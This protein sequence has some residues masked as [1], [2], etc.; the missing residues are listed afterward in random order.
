MSS[1]DS[2]AHEARLGVLVDRFQVLQESD[3]SIG[4]GVMRDEAGEHFGELVELVGC[5]GVLKA[6]FGEEPDAEQLP[7]AIGGYAIQ[8]VL[9]RGVSGVVYRAVDPNGRVVA[10][11]VMHE[12]LALSVEALRRFEREVEVAERL[13]HPAIVSMFR[14][15]EADGRLF[16][17]M[18]LIDGDTLAA[19]TTRIHDEGGDPNKVLDEYGVAD[20]VGATPKERFARR[21]ALLCAPV[22][23]ALHHAAGR[24]MIHRDLK[25]GNLL[26]GR[27]GRLKVADFGLAK[28]LGEELTSTVAVLGTPGF[29]SPEQA[30]GR[31]REVTGASDIYGLAG[32]IYRV[33]SGEYP[34]EAPSFNE[35]LAA[36]MHER[37]KSI[38]EY[39]AD[40]PR[41][42]ARVLARC[43]EKAPEDRYPT[44]QLLATD[45]QRIALGK[46]PLSSRIPAARRA[47]RFAERHRAVLGAGAAVVLLGVVAFLVWS[48]RPAGLEFTVLPNAAAFLNDQRI[49]PGSHEL[50]RGAY[51]LV[52]RL[53]GWVETRKTFDL[54][55]GDNT[56]FDIVLRPNDPNDLAKI[57][58]VLGGLP[59]ADFPRGRGIG[60][61]QPPVSDGKALEADLKKLPEQWR[62]QPVGYLRALNLL[63][64]QGLHREVYHG[65][66]E[67]ARMVPD[68][69]EPLRF[70]LDALL[71]LRL[72]QTRIYA[73]L[74]VRWK[75]LGGG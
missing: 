69:P 36:I 15:G 32:T 62:D 52:A 68:K 18:E 24:G 70:A 71:E 65:A 42:L 63:R 47:R 74:F 67:L 2:A 57:A 34:V 27:D 30:A 28:M 72:E 4:V 59:E 12:S 17:S 19:V 54:G 16:L 22:A 55:P 60:D 45:L 39:S 35:M 21:V 26:L 9:G 51:V 31:S 53:D 56:S 3:P 50:K 73:N 13:D 75:E 44:A 7:D 1:P 10:L 25:P 29:M 48:G 49:D 64:K 8:R 11:K 58:A 20:A 40:Y 46:P 43:L 6:G 37:P 5:L 66:L 61:G 23:E 38:T 33:L 14:H 41:D